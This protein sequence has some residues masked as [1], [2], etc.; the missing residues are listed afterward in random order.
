LKIGE[1]IP[2]FKIVTHYFK[3]VY[4]I[5][6]LFNNFPITSPGVKLKQLSK[7]KFQK[8]VD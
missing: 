1:I 2:E 8:E 7:I 3:V 4:L 6:W 5:F